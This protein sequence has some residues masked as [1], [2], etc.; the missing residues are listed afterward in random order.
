MIKYPQELTLTMKKWA[1]HLTSAHLARPYTRSLQTC[2]LCKDALFPPC[3]ACLVPF[4]HDICRA[5]PLCKCNICIRVHQGLPSLLHPQGYPKLS[6]AEAHTRALA[7]CKPHDALFTN[8][9][10][11]LKQ[12]CSLDRLLHLDSPYCQ[13]TSS[14][15]C[16]SLC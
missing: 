16:T 13:C 11:R 7:A 10:L 2:T 6:S 3:T 9:D 8:K 1:K 12:P 15:C 5:T 4:M 14:L